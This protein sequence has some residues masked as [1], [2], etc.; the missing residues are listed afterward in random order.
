MT[1][2]LIVLG[3]AASLATVPLLAQTGRPA[4]AADELATASRQIPRTLD[5]KPNFEGE[6]V[7]NTFTPLERPDELKDKEFF[8]PEEAK[9]MAERNIARQKAQPADALH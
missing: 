1:K 6:W 2:S 5:G 9:A 8:T 7:N 3:V 4:R